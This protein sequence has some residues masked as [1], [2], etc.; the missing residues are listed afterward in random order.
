MNELASNAP[1][2]LLLEYDSR[3]QERQLT[4]PGEQNLNNQWSG[5]AFRL[6]ADVLLAPMDQVVEIIDPPACTL[7]PGTRHWF[8]GLA[9]VRGN[10]LPV[11]DLHGFILG[12]RASTRRNA[13]LLVYS[14]DG[15]YA[16]LKVDDILGLKQFSF[17]EVS[18]EQAR[19]HEALQ[20]Y[21]EKRFKRMDD[22]WPVFS[23]TRFVSSE[24]FLGVVK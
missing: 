5:I 17:D 4:L 6:G 12:G 21:I 22:V 13:R 24:S 9:N 14:R 16:G 7:V 1:L 8:L 2:D 15:I 20:P 19:V 3:M 18:T 11:T 23:L 10:L